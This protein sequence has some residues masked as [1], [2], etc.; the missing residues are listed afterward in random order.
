MSPPRLPSAHRAMVGLWGWGSRLDPVFT[1]GSTGCSAQVEEQWRAQIS[2]C[3][4]PCLSTGQCVAGSCKGWRP[5]VSVRVW[6]LAPA[7]QSPRGE[8]SQG[9]ETLAAALCRCAPGS[10]GWAKPCK[11]ISPHPQEKAGAEL[12]SR[13]CSPST[14]RFFLLQ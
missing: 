4:S 11:T 3:C 5:S 7:A 10:K 8:I 12:V 2:P 6:L 9:M 1:G 13:G 14:G